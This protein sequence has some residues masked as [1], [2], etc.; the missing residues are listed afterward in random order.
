MSTNFDHVLA[1]YRQETDPD[2]A[3]N[4]YV[5]ALPG[6][7]S[8]RELAHALALV[9]QATEA[10]RNGSVE[11]RLSRVGSLSQ[12]CIPLTRVIDLASAM[13]R[14]LFEGYRNRRPFTPADQKN[15]QRLYEAQQAG[16]VQ[17]AGRHHPANQLSM[18]LFGNPGSGKSFILRQIGNLFPP[19]IFHERSGRWQVPF[20]FIEMPYDGMSVYTLASQIFISLEKKMPGSDYVKH[21]TENVKL[22]AERLLMKALNVAYELGVGMIVVDEAQNS[23]ATG[24][25]LSAPPG[26]R[27]TPKKVS[28]SGL[29]KLLITAS[30]IG[31]MPLMFTGTMELMPTLT[32]RASPARR[33]VGRGS[34][35]WQPLS[36]KTTED[37]QISEFDAFMSVM[38]RCQWL[39]KPAQYSSDW[40]EVFFA[41]TQG[42][43][44]YMVKL[45]ESAQARA[46]RTG[47]ASLTIEDVTAAYDAEFKAGEA[48]ITAVQN[49]DETALYL[50]AD[51]FGYQPEGLKGQPT[52]FS[53]PRR[54]ITHQEPTTPQD[55]VAAINQRKKV[56]AARSS[57]STEGKSPKP[58]EVDAAPIVSSDLRKSKIVPASPLAGATA[59]PSA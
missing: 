54:A 15:H 18:A 47:A 32:T 25:Q 6:L 7:L 52:G 3:G 45:F 14:L 44:D 53:P 4:I 27:S 41:Y 37:S 22:N 36:R 31:N 48:T 50:M 17:K 24:N 43:P 26:T 9:P 57:A 33:M 23:K 28:E 35:A 2:Y 30:N 1:S 49:P 13:H 55:I 40:S 39:K 21:Y 34:A 16:H 58:M 19:V 56:A 11:F 42:I 10:E 12:L 46:I 29:M 38:F 51:M 59:T 20:L 5:E 8:R